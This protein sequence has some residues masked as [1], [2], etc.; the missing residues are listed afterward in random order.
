MRQCY[1]NARNNDTLTRRKL[2]DNQ[3]PLRYPRKKQKRKDLMAKEN[4]NPIVQSPRRLQDGGEI[5]MY[6]PDDTVQLEV[7]VDDDSVW[8]T[9]A[10]MSLLF[11]TTRAN[12]T[13]HIGNIFKE[14]ELEKNSVCKDFLQ[15]AADGKSYHTAFYNLDVIIS[16]GYRIK[17]LNGTRFRQWATSV[18]RE[19]TLRGYAISHRLQEMEQRIDNRLLEQTVA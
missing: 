14:H 4:T 7:R 10:Q 5:V 9:Q 3:L 18:L 1:K 16:V 13:L 17:S 15:T 6:R 2:A 11:G 12:V 19:Y 8:L